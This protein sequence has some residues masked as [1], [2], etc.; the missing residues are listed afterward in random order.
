MREIASRLWSLLGGDPLTLDRLELVG[1][2]RVLPSVFDVTGLAAAAVGVATLAAAELQVARDDRDVEDVAVTTREASAAF[3]CENLFVP[4]G[5]TL[6][7]IWDPIAGDYQTAD[8]WIRLHTNYAHHRAAVMRALGLRDGERE[9]VATEVA[10]WKG[11]DPEDRVVGEGGAAAAMRT[12]EQW[13]TH[14]H[15][16]ATASSLPIEVIPGSGRHERSLPCP[17]GV[18]G[19]AAPTVSRSVTSSTATRC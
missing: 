16:V 8:G 5:W 2:R 12:R 9:T 13:L 11:D 10:G 3:R 7:P 14:P 17:T 19:P 6:P 4:E 18:A 1:H 15:G